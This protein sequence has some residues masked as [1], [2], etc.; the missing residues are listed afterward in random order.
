[1][2]YE[3]RNSWQEGIYTSVMLYCTCLRLRRFDIDNPLQNWINFI[4]QPLQP[5]R[6]VWCSVQLPGQ[7]QGFSSLKNFSTRGPWKKTEAACCP[8]AYLQSKAASSE[9]CRLKRCDWASH[10]ELPFG[11]C[12]NS[13]TQQSRWMKSTVPEDE[14]NYDMDTEHT[15][16]VYL[17]W[18]TGL[19]Q[20]LRWEATAVAMSPFP[21]PTSSVCSPLAERQD[22]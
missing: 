15:P 12:L 1:M 10:C 4:E 9:F 2:L 5:V 22:L 8:S 17:Q 16:S 11:V 13:N 14:E 20:A 6:G 19:R 18:S 3:D 21:I 7:R